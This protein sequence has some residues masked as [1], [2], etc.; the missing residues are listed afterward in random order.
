MR[1]RWHRFFSVR[2]I[3]LLMQFWTAKRNLLFCMFEYRIDFVS[4]QIEMNTIRAVHLFLHIWPLWRPS[5]CQHQHQKFN[6]KGPLSTSFPIHWLIRKKKGTKCIA[7]ALE[8]ANGMLLLL[9]L[10]LECRPHL[11]RNVALKYCAAKI[12]PRF[13]HLAVSHNAHI[14]HNKNTQAIGWIT[15]TYTATITQST[16][17]STKDNRFNIIIVARS[18]INVHLLTATRRR[19]NISSDCS[20]CFMLMLYAKNQHKDLSNVLSNVHKAYT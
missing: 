3:F 18:L 7:S 19:S 10:R 9:L 6:D 17:L 16:T 11:N 12:S 8:M 14:T 5:H 20:R 1:L 4:C 15:H 13:R 2:H